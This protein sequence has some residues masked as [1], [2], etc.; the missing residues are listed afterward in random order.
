MP[1]VIASTCREEIKTEFNESVD[2]NEFCLENERRDCFG[3]ASG[4]A[5]F[6]KDNLVHLGGIVSR[7]LECGQH[8]HVFYY[9]AIFTKTV[10]FM[11]WI[12]NT[13]AA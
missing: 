3:E 1:T 13:T 5:L 6:I 2:S 10:S 8:S 11:E 7:A 4:M 9:P 12:R